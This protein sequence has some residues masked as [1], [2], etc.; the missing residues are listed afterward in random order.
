[1]L[2]ISFYAS[3]ESSLDDRAQ[4]CDLGHHRF[5]KH[6]AIQRHQDR[7]SLLGNRIFHREQLCSD[8]IRESVRLLIDA[9][10]HNVSD[11][12]NLGESGGGCE[13]HYWNLR[14]AEPDPEEIRSRAT[15]GE[16]PLKD[17]SDTCRSEFESMQKQT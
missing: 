12:K 16:N 15:K 13:G 6:C 10:E 11:P 4:V 7:R 1:M 2:S 9:L 3:T 14:E 8:F 17:F 5:A